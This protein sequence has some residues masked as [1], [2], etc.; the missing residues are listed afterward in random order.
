MTVPA[1]L[2]RT[3]PTEKSCNGAGAGVPPP[4]V[5]PVRWAPMQSW[6]EFMGGMALVGLVFLDVFSTVL[7]PRAAHRGVRLGPLMGRVLGGMWRRVARRLPSPRLRQDFRGS[8]APLLLVL[9]LAL[10]IAI[11]ASGFALMLH[12]MPDDARFPSPDL[13][14]AGFQAASALSTLGLLNAH[15]S[16][17]ARIIV[18]VAGVSGF[19]I[20]SLVVAFLLSI[21]NALHRREELVIALAAR[22]GRPPRAVALL[23]AMEGAADEEMADLFLAW[24]RWTADVM[25]SHLSYPVLCRFRSLDE[26]AEWLSCLGVVLD[27]A[28]LVRAGDRGDYPRAVRAAGFLIETAKRACIELSR[29]L[30]I[31]RKTIDAKPAVEGAVAEAEQLGFADGHPDTRVRLVERERRVYAPT[32]EAIAHQLDIVWTG[33]LVDEA[34]LP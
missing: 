23:A 29:L 17:P 34:T 27:A 31:R 12:S 11:L 21:Q 15:V 10:W 24:E 1:M 20:V 9:S 14:E 22:A 16:G 13:A 6:I 18:A 30:G 2:T 25:Q 3:P 28:A 5:A 4:F 26:N 7:V 32:L 33:T 8:L 19:A